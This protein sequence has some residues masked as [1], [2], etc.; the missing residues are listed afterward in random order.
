[1][2]VPAMRR[3]VRRRIAGGR[4]ACFPRIPRH[5]RI[6]DRTRLVVPP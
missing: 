6:S 1:M 5:R 3:P 2:T 4:P